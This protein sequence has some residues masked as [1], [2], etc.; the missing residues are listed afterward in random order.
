MLIEQKPEKGKVV[1]VKLISGDEIVGK[2]EVLNAKE[3][4]LSKP[5]AVGVSPQQQIGFATFMVSVDDDAT[6]TFKLEQIITYALAREEIKN[7]YIQSTSGITPVGA[8]N[9]PEGLVGA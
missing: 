1:A 7:A 9:L 3:I 2:I 4:V 6:L 5:I 8:G